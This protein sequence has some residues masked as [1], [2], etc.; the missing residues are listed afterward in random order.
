MLRR[1][2]SDFAS[3]WDA[4]VNFLCAKDGLF[5]LFSIIFLLYFFTLFPINIMINIL[6][7]FIDL[8]NPNFDARKE[9]YELHTCSM[10]NGGSLAMS[11]ATFCNYGYDKPRKKVIQELQKVLEL[12]NNSMQGIILRD[13]MS[14]DNSTKLMCDSIDGYKWYCVSFGNEINKDLFCLFQE[15]ISFKKEG[16]TTYLSFDEKRKQLMEEQLSN[17]F[18]FNVQILLT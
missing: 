5:K 16:R 1:I 12:N 10:A 9:Y 13:R 15:F 7:F 3:C 2:H 14:P 4:F 6:R 8:C 17:L 18:K 11:Y